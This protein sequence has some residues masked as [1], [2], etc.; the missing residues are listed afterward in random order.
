MS[1]LLLVLAIL[2]F[3]ALLLFLALLPV[4]RRARRQKAE[5]EAELGDSARRS[6]NRRASGSSRAARGRYAGTAGSC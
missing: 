4:A 6:E 5:L 1:V 3:V 2:A